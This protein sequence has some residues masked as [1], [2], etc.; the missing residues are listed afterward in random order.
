VGQGARQAAGHPGGTGRR[1]SLGLGPA[2]PLRPGRHGRH[3]APAPRHR[4][5]LLSVRRA[6]ARRGQGPAPRLGGPRRRQRD[7][8]L[9]GIHRS[10]HGGR[11]RGAG[12]G[13]PRGGGLEWAPAAPGRCGRLPDRVR[14]PALPPAE[15]SPPPRRGASSK[16]V[17]PTPST[18]A[19]PSAAGRDDA[20][21]PGPGGA[22]RRRSRGSGRVSDRPFGRRGR[23]PRR[24]H[25]GASRA[26]PL[27]EGPPP[28]LPRRPEPARGRADSPRTSTAATSRPTR[29][30]LDSRGRRRG[31][32]SVWS[33]RPPAVGVA[34]GA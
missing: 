24:H 11:G 7:G 18:G 15:P 12:A 10:A 6:G 22:P 9:P 28:A 26:D 31:L 29:S 20:L 30:S 25:G 27:P 23:D 4:R 14:L 33:Q 1:L 5:R 16:S 17:G 34:G 32:R 19:A 21:A 2:A 13:P 3:R 8:R